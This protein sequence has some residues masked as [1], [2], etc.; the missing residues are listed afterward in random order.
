METKPAPASGS[1]SKQCWLM[2]AEPDSRI[3]KGK[4]V[5]FSVDIF[6]ASPN[7]TTSWDGVRNPEA[8]QMM[9]VVM[10]NN[11]DVLFYH[12][13][14]KLPGATTQEKHLFVKWRIP[15][16][17]SP[18][19]SSRHCWTGKDCQRRL[20]RSQCMGSSECIKGIR[21]KLI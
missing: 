15:N 3:E 4:D 6:A 8:K 1:L 9:K 17:E 12:S 16:T 10:K 11:D 2:K 13:N 20:S 18:I 21:I 14:C 7:K 19:Y 5:A